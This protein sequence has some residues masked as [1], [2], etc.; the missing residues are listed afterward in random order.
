MGTVLLA[1]RDAAGARKY[2]EQAVALDPN[3]IDGI[4]GLIAIDVAAKRYD[5][6][7]SRVNAQLARRPQEP[8]LIELAART[9]MA[10]N[11]LGTAERHL[12]KLMEVA[13]ERLAAY[14]LLAHLYTR[15]QRL[16]EAREQL[17][18]LASKQ[19]NPVGP[20]T[21][22][23]MLLE[24]QGRSDEARKMYEHVLSYE[25]RAAVAANNLAWAMAERND[26]LDLA[27]KYAQTA[28]SVLP[29]QPEVSD[30]LAWVYYKKDLA[31]LAVEPLEHAVKLDPMNP[32]Y[33]YHLGL[34][35][36]K[37]GNRTGARQSLQ[38]ALKLN[39]TF[40]GA[41]DAKSKLE[42]L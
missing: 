35:Y 17:S 42:G 4:A 36:L 27:L 30:T 38:Q 8:R 19:K 23:A 29:D 9:A 41:G 24:Q 32:G 25:P 15:Q 18:R 11:D 7:R 5:A 37:L 20:Q 14:S 28:K 10:S 21:L 33:H 40:P 12:Q 39:S 3:S 31:S 1:R 26:N 6:A 34:V 16:D 22:I 13:P 2:F